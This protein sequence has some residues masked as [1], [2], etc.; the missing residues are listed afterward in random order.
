MRKT[1]MRRSHWRIIF[2]AG[3][4]FFTDAYDL[5]IIG[6]VTALIGP[7]WGLSIDQIALLNG[8]ALLAAA[9]GAI[10]FGLLSDRLGRKKLYGIEVLILFFG[11]IASALATSFWWLFIARFIMG[12]GIGGDYPTSAVVASEYAPQRNRGYMVLLVF[13]MQAL[14]MIFGPALASLM[15]M[16]PLAHMDI[17]RILLGF[18]AIPAASVFILRRQLQ[19]TPEFKKQANLPLS[20]SRVV[21]DIVK[22]KGNPK[23][24]GTY[25]RQS[26][27]QSKWLKTLLIT[28]GSWFL[29]DVA[30]Y[31]NTVSNMM[32]LNA[33]QPDASLL[34]HTAMTALI[35][36][37]FAVPGYFLAA[38]YIDQIGRK[39]LQLLGFAVM[40]MC[41]C[42]IGSFPIIPKTIVLFLLIYGVSYFFTNFG[43]NTTTFLVPSEV[44]PT[45]LRA[46]GHGLSAAIGKV[47]AAIGAFLLPG[48]LKLHGLEYVMIGMCLVALV[49]VGLSIFL[50]DMTN[51]CLSETEEMVTNE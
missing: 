4:G 3:M 41:Y 10:F 30:L 39:R 50:P 27:W 26:L 16:T 31:G 29:L 21:R 43:P 51:R 5:F 38:A 13:A 49:G 18:G 37:V 11:A 8:S 35:F 34:A 14:G 47:G 44:Y 46:T 7:I 24:V 9:L 33:I 42:A 12:F 40:A 25:K 19:E 2:T 45:S 22:D 23:P 1:D 36:L 17:A 20:V 6:V 32:I 28:G 15:L 48:I